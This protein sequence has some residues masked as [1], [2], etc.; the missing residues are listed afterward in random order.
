MKWLASPR[1]ALFFVATAGAL[2]L[3]GGCSGCE[4]GNDDLGGGGSGNGTNSGPNGSTGN[5]F[6]TGTDSTGTMGQGGGCAGINKIAEKVPLDMYIMLDQSGSMSDSAQGGGSKWQAVTN[7]LST[8]VNQPEA[9]GIGVGIQYF[10][11]DSGANG[12]VLHCTDTAQCGPGCGPCDMPIPGFG[13]CA[14][15][16]ASDSCVPGDYATPD[17]GIAVLPGNAAA[18]GTS[19]GAHGPTGGTPTSAALDGAIQHPNT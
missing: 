5:G 15:F 14:G 12:N 7:A 8:F 1:R 16:G 19:M 17:V 4:A 13:V 6:S 2:A 10:P 11:L 18:S 9:A 3:A